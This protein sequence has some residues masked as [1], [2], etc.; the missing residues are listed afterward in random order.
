MRAASISALVL[1]VALAAVIWHF[2]APVWTLSQ[3]RRA[4]E[5]RDAAAL[6][7]FVDFTALR[8][9]LETEFGAAMLAEMRDGEARIGPLGAA[10]GMARLD[11]VIDRLVTPAGVRT[12]FATAASGPPPPVRI[13]AEFEI[14]RE[15]FS[16]FRVVGAGAPAAGALVFRRKG[17]VWRLAAIDLPADALSATR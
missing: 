13:G 2:T 1:T 9:S 10:L 16:T 4:A 6:A 17:R 12:I 15:G 7:S 14:E 3:M 11:P 5:A 8:D